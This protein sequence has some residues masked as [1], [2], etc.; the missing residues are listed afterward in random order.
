[1]RCA[2][3]SELIDLYLDGDLSDESRARVQRHL[4]RCESCAY[5][6][7]SMDQARELLRD[8]HPHAQSSPSFRERASARLQDSF[9]DVLRREPAADE[10]QWTLPFRD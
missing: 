6:L 7:R 4:I 1:M 9:S 10:T 3:I 8:A 2:D 5:Q